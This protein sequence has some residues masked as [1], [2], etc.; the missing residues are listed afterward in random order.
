MTPNADEIAAAIALLR[1]TQAEWLAKYNRIIADKLRE[2]SAAGVSANAFCKR[3]GYDPGYMSRV[4]QGDCGVS[5]E[6][7]RKIIA[8]LDDALCSIQ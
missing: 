6:Q 7:A 8:D 4:A 1:H 2:L 5:C 3:Y